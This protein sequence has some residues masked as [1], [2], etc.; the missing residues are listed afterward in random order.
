MDVAVID[1]EGEDK[2]T[3]VSK[4]WIT[5]KGIC[6]HDSDRTM[7]SDGQ[8]LYGTHLSAVQFFF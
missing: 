4:A 3:T 1:N 5:I 7:L 6:L 2:D 8:W